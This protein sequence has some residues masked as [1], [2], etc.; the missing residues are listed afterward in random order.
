MISLDKIPFILNYF[1]TGEKYYLRW[2]VVKCRECGKDITG[3][4]YDISPFSSVNVADGR[5]IKLPI[6]E[7]TSID[8]MVESAYM[9]AKDDDSLSDATDV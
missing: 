5:D 1:Y 8:A 3:T 4:K 6:D 2:M 7:S 9:L